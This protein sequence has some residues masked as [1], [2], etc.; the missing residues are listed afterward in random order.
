MKRTHECG[1]Y[2]A[3]RMKRP[4]KPAFTHEETITEIE[5]GAG[6]HFDPDIAKVF[7]DNHQIM[8]EIFRLNEDGEDA[9]VGGGS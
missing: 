3:L 5:K 1:V 4:Y 7:I 2:D 9:A 6:N 8:E